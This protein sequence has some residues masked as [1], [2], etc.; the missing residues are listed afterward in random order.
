ML[1]PAAVM[2]E[3]GDVF[4]HHQEHLTV[5]TASDIVHLCCCQPVS[6]TRLNTNKQK[7]ASCWSTIRISLE[8][9]AWEEGVDWIDLAHDRDR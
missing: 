6:W 5:F 4:A 2:D 8:E 9:I 7:V 1:L 3:L